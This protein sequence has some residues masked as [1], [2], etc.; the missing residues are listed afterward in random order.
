MAV[1]LLKLCV[2]VDSVARLAEFQA[3]RLERLRAA[4]ERPVLCHVTRHMPRR[5]AELCEGGSLYWVVRGFIAVRQRLLD[6]KAR[7]NAEG[8]PSCALVLDPELVR[9]APRACR[10]FQGWRYL[11]AR[12]APPDAESGPAGTEDLP[13]EMAAELRTLGLL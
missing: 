1:H 5:A 2:G 9:V 7:T 10:P 12:K 8:R 4:G 13:E 6:C 11:D 3:A